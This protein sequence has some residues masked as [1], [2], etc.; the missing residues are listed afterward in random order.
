VLKMDCYKCFD[1]T[2]Q[3][4]AIVRDPRFASQVPPTAPSRP[5]DWL[6]SS[7][8]VQGNTLS[9]V[10]CSVRSVEKISYGD[11]E[12]RL[13]GLEQ[14]VCKEQTS[15]LLGAIKRIAERHAIHEH[16]TLREVVT[17]IEADFDVM[18]VAEALRGN[19]YDGNL[20]RPRRFEIAAAISR[21]RV[22]GI[23]IPKV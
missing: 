22:P 16:V 7:R 17:A 8:I 9:D 23:L 14:L 3:A 13:H 10:K 12:I 1:V 19:S 21:L 5:N 20:A 15:A 6:V 18:G 4:R 2:D 11:V